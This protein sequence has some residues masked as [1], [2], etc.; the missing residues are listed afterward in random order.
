MKIKE[1]HRKK[2]SHHPRVKKTSAAAGI[3]F[4][5][6]ER[7][8]P[9]RIRIV[10]SEGAPAPVRARALC[11]WGCCRRGGYLREPTGFAYPL[12]GDFTRIEHGMA[13]RER[14]SP[15][16]PRGPVSSRF[17]Q[18]N[19]VTDESVP[20]L[21][22]PPVSFRPESLIFISGAEKLEKPGDFPSS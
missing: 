13:E 8:S 16:S 21:V 15:G 18:I 11:R 6:R 22:H 9:A 19:P 12:Q 4:E 17:V 20:A 5:E 10:G 1:T 2:D 7:E 14:L 3:P